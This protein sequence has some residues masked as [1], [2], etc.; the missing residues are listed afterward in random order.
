MNCRITFINRACVPCA[1]EKKMYI[2][3]PIADKIE[4]AINETKLSI[5]ENYPVFVSS[6][7]KYSDTWPLY[8]SDLFF[9]HPLGRRFKDI[10]ENIYIILDN[11]TSSKLFRGARRNRE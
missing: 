8:F 5:I 9:R 11:D 6:A 7:Q 10:V 3:S 2:D 1:S 4:S